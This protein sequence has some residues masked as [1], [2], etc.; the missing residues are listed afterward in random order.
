MYKLNKMQLY[1][2]LY[3][4]TYLIKREENTIPC[5]GTNDDDDDDNKNKIL[6]SL[7]LL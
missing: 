3:N 7:T 1:Y 4:I 6:S 5:I 2:L